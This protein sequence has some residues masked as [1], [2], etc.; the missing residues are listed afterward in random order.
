MYFA[1]F[2][3]YVPDV[4]ERRSAYR[5][6]HLELARQAHREGRLILAGAFNPTDGALLV[7]RAESA[8]DVEAFARGDPYVRN[9]LVRAWRVREW[10]VVVGGDAE[11]AAGSR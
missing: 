5:A 9:G 3:D 6:E 10:T 4:L 1:L 11:Q 7:F 8:T 2:Y